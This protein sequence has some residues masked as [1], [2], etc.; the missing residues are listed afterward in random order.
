MKRSL[1]YSRFLMIVLII[2][3]FSGCAGLSVQ[4]EKK[5][6]KFIAIP[7][8]C[9]GGL[10]ESDLTSYL[11]APAGDANFIALDAGTLL[12]GLRQAKKKG[13]LQ[14]IKIPPDS[15]LNLEGVVL[16]N[17][18]KAY[19]ISHAHLDHIAGMVINAPDDSSKPI[20]GLPST[21]DTIR[22]HMFNWKTWPNPH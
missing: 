10:I 1:D 15:P 18:I 6:A 17:H 4:G 21:I 5:D 3:T 11:L 9:K 8:G 22:D 7:L 20:L 13:S 12:A 16:K 2:I 19:A 14:N